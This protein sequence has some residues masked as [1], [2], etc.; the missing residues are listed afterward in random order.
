MSSLSGVGPLPLCG[1]L[2]RANSCLLPLAQPLLSDPL[3][4]AGTS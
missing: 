4:P 3:R 2:T 1:V